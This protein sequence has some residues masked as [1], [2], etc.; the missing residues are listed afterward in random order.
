MSLHVHDIELR[1][2]LQRDF[3]RMRKGSM[4]GRRKIR[5]MEDGKV[6]TELSQAHR[7]TRN[8]ISFGRKILIEC[9]TPKLLEITM[10]VPMV[11]GFITIVGRV[12]RP[13]GRPDLATNTATARR[14][15]HDPRG[16]RAGLDHP[17]TLGFDKNMQSDEQSIRKLVADWHKATAAG[18]LSKILDLMAEDV[19][20]YV[21]GHP[22]IFGKD[23]FAAVFR[24][25]VQQVR[26]ESSARIEELEVSGNSAHLANYLTVTMTPLQSGS[27]MRRSGYTLTIL[28]K[29]P[30]GRWLLYRD[31]NM[32]AA[33]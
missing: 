1:L 31:A 5:W 27:V 8:F 28:R 4:A 33:E 12:K 10:Q 24:A 20:F 25:A 18:D 13:S 32:L 19:A 29:Q 11:S 30:D 23:A 15:I 14:P 2:R 7:H 3:K 26:I 21:V 16:E 22:P 17:P 9:K 6:S